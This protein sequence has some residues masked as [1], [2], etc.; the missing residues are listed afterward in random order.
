[1]ILDK[2]KIFLGPPDGRTNNV[3]AP[4]PRLEVLFRKVRERPFNVKVRKGGG[5]MFFPIKK[6]C[7]QAGDKIN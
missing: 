1:M 4:T 5:V 6:C 2:K 7:G 3:V